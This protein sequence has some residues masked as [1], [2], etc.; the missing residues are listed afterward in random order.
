MTKEELKILQSYPLDIKIEKTKA[1]IREWVRY[2]GEDQVTVSFSGGKDSTVLLHIVRSEFPNIKAVFCDT[3]LEYP[4]IKEFVKQ[5]DNVEIVRPNKSFKQVITEYGYPVI[6]KE[7]SACINE[8][9][10]SK[11]EKLRNRRLYGDSKGRFKLSESWRYLLDAPFKISDKCCY[12]LKKG[13]LFRF[14]RKEKSHPIIGTMA[15]E[16]WL[17]RSA[18]L[19]L[20]CN[21]F[22]SKHPTSKPLSFW[23]QQ[24]ILRYIKNNNLKISSCYGEVVEEDPQISFFDSDKKLKCTG[25]KRTG[26]IFCAYGCHR[27]PNP[28]RFQLLK[29]THPDLYDYCIHG[30]GWSKDGLWCPNSQGLGFSKVLDWINVEYE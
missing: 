21:A 25:V 16:S 19:R 1:R 26:C 10:N 24:D 29:Q 18:Y 22:E 11:S 13:P 27:D 30:G 6:S 7:Q 12:H 5:T 20:G 14:E 15:E 9:R 28:N 17:R 8:I 2:W 3:G 4:E 23:R